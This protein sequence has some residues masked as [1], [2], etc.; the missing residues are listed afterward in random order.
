MYD[1]IAIA[2]VIAV[3]SQPFLA[4]TDDDRDVC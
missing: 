2:I 3:A 1:E 4:I